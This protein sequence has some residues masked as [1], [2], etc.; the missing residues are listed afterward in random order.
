MKPNISLTCSAIFLSGAVFSAS[1]EVTAQTTA[2]AILEEIV[3]TARRRE[4]SL[5]DV[6]SSVVAFSGEALRGEAVY[7]TLNLSD[8]AA[9]LSL[10]E[11]DQRGRHSLAIRGIGAVRIESATAQAGAGFYIDGHYLASVVGSTMNTLDIERVEVLRGPQGTLFG[12]N[13]T[14]GAVNI[15]TTKPQNEFGADLS[16]RAAEYGGQE[17]RGMVNVPFT[18]N[19]YGRFTVASEQSDGWA[20]NRFLNRGVDGTDTQAARAA[21]RY[22]PSD[23][24]TLDFAVSSERRRDGQNPFSCRVLPTPDLV[25]ALANQHPGG[26]FDVEGEMVALLPGNDPAVAALHPPSIWD[27]P[28]A[29]DGVGPNGRAGSGGPFATELDDDVFAYIGGI[30]EAEG[31][32]GATVALWNGCHADAAAGDFVTS[33]NHVEFTDIDVEAIFLATTWDSLGA[34]G[35]FDNLSVWFNASYRNRLYDYVVDL[36]NTPMD[37]KY[38]ASNTTDSAENFSRSAELIFDATVNDR[39]SFLTGLYF[40]GEQENV[41]TEECFFVAVEQVLPNATDPFNPVVPCDGSTIGAHFFNLEGIATDQLTGF[42][43]DDESRAVFANMV[44]TLSDAWNLELG[45]RYTEDDREF[46]S[47]GFAGTNCVMEGNT[48]VPGSCELGFGPFVGL[49]P[50]LAERIFDGQATFDEVTP[51]FSLT[52]SL[53]G[54]DTLDNGIVYFLYSKG[55]LGGGF[56]D[57]I[58]ANSPPV[59]LALQTFDSETVDNYEVGFKGTFADGRASL[60]TALFYMDYRDKQEELEI[61]NPDP[62]GSE[63]TIESFEN[64]GQVDIFGVEVE[65]RA[66]P[67]NGGFVTVDAGYL[68]QEYNEFIVPDTENPGETIDLSNLGIQDRSPDWTLNVS[69]GH[70]FVLGNGG[71]LTPTLG[72][73]AQDEYEWLRRNLDSPASF[74]HQD[75]FAKARARLSYEH[76]MPSRTWELTA[77]GENINDERYLADCRVE[78]SSGMYQVYYGAPARWGLE[79]VARF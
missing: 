14:G 36:D 32:S 76:E 30:E 12:K 67:W 71:G 59:L 62:N 74:C 43:R 5:A 34:V 70:T 18:D 27:G 21:L 15:I 17:L 39:L 1:E 10:S 6:P 65:L 7:N 11:S 3:V 52:R 69:V 4:E 49:F 64:A 72:I 45:V 57:E 50:L 48:T 73:Y 2:D 8:Y 35:A 20:H 44:Y 68:S 46:R 24:W 42:R 28:T 22:E 79:F 75:G 40:F 38:Q 31:G 23:N 66:S 9:N 25:E 26:T 54:G 29:A 60:N 56:N 53:A 58:F 13:V 37:I 41:G 19:L 55:Y 63:P 47:T 77:Y 61:P 33:D 78:D 51:R 16:L